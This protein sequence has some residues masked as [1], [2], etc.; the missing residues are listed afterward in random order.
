MQQ[1]GARLLSRAGEVRGPHGVDALRGVRLRL[2]SVHLGVPGAVDDPVGALALHHPL[3]RSSV[4]DGE[5]GVAEGHQ[6]NGR[7]SDA[8]DGAAEHSPRADE[9]DSHV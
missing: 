7:R 2:G 3:D 9:E 4:F 5:I 1:A 8:L 6:L